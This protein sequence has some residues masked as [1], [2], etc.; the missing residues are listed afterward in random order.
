M[1]ISVLI[2]KQEYSSELSGSLLFLNICSI[3]AMIFGFEE[4]AKFSLVV[5][6]GKMG[7]TAYRQTNTEVVSHK[8]DG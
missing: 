7:I 8:T 6:T 5:S 1:Y 4:A 2:K 3:I